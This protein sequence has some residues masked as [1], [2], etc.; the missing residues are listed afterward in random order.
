MAS[1]LP[2]GPSDSAAVVV[3]ASRPH[4]VAHQ[5]FGLDCRTSGGRLFRP[6]TD[7]A[8]V[9]RSQRRGMVGLGTD[10]SLDRQQ[11]PDSRLLLHARNLVATVPSSRVPERVAWAERRAISGGTPPDSTVRPPLPTAR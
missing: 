7:R 8:R 9:S 11:D 2:G 10:V 5:P 6:A 3:T 4:R 1:E